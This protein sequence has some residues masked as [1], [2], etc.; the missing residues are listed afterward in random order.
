MEHFQCWNQLDKDLGTKLWTQYIF[1]HDLQFNQQKSSRFTQS[2][3]KI[4]LKCPKN[5][6]YYYGFFFFLNL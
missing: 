6:F 4:E 1:K 3:G 2:Q 5:N